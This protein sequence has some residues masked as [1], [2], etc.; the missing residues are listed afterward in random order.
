MKV[1]VFW[2]FD[3]I[4][5]V[6]VMNL[7]I[8]W[9]QM[10]AKYVKMHWT[11]SKSLPLKWDGSHLNCQII[12]SITSLSLYH[13]DIYL[14]RLCWKLSFLLENWLHI[15][16]V[17]SVP[18]SVHNSILKMSWEVLLKVLLLYILFLN[19]LK[20]F[21]F[22]S[23]PFIR[24]SIL[25]HLVILCRQ[26]LMRR[27]IRKPSQCFVFIFSTSS[28]KNWIKLHKQSVLNECNHHF[29]LHSEMK[30]FSDWV[31]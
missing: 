13:S 22:R 19:V 5:S 20:F 11:P 31:H 1:N 12:W 6:L 9:N 23:Q 27:N 10:N 3:M 17:I 14:Y 26:Q 18:G 29:I 16:K 24:L 30:N 21:I 25:L 2:R 28:K 8:W 4:H 7:H 15:W